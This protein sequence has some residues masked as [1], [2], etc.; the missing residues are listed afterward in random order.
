MTVHRPI[1]TR[2]IQT[3]LGPL[4]V[5]ETGTGRRTIVL[6]PSIFTDHRIHL[7]LA[8]RL[9]PRHRLLLIDGP[10]HGQSPGPG[11][12]F[13]LGDCARAMRAV[14]DAFG[15]DRA[16]VGG[17][18]W[19]GLAG[20]E[21]ALIAPDR[22]EAL[23]LLNTPFH[24]GGP[25]P[26][27]S[28]RL[29]ATGARWGLRTRTFRDGVARSFFSPEALARDPAYARAFHDMLRSAAPAPFAAAI[30]SVLL[31][32]TPLAD[33]AARI[34]VPTLVLAGEADPMYPAEAQR[35]AAAR[36]PGARFA[37]VPGRHISAI[38]SPDAV[39]H[40]IGAFLG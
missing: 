2:M 31:R 32:G 40:E 24:L 26:P 4:A 21:L 3:I 13:T 11:G 9:G 15:L 22:I 5:T 27:L 17:T 33:R 29:I 7:P 25:R 34:A 20:A 37:L 39:A 38:D 6:W 36:I 19:G 1:D 16:V 10:A 28:A 23:L 35:A 14:L 18:S 30:R 8:G 12:E